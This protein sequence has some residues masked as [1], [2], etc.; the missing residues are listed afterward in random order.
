MKSTRYTVLLLTM[1]RLMLMTSLSTLVVLTAC[2]QQV[3]ID[4]EKAAIQSTAADHAEATSRGGAEGA[5]AYAAY[6]TAD[7]RWLPPEAPAITGREAIAQFVAPFTEMEGFQVT[8]DHPH[9]VVSRGGDIA[10]SVGTYE[11]SGQD[12]EGTTQVFEGK[13]VN[14]WHKQPD[15][16]WKIAVAIWNTNQPATQPEAA[17]QE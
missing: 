12:A 15:G 9:V 16:S 2:Q 6:A 7:A 3:D 8:W 4:A 5:E 14:V 17:V 1:K 13:F 11:G 10:Y